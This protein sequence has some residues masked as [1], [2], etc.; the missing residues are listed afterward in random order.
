MGLDGI[1]KP[2]RDDHV[3]SVRATGDGESTRICRANQGLQCPTRK[4][5]GQV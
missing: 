1:D 4:R 2:I 5:C 3:R